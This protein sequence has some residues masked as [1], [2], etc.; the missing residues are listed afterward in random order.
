MAPEQSASTE[1]DSDVLQVP[2]SQSN[3]SEK[4]GKR[5]E[6]EAIL[7]C[8]QYLLRFHGIEK[9]IASIREIAEV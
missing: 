2:D 6:E 1:K 8:L 3:H 4:P 5:V 9:S 7:D